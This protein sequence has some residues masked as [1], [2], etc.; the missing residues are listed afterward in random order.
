M[1]DLASN[2]IY[3]PPASTT[4][5]RREFNQYRSN[6]RLPRSGSRSTARRSRHIQQPSPFTSPILE[7]EDALPGIGVSGGGLGVAGGV[8]SSIIESGRQHGAHMSH[9]APYG[10]SGTVPRQQ[11]Q[12]RHVQHAGLRKAGIPTEENCSKEEDDVDPY[13]RPDEGGE[14]NMHGHPSSEITGV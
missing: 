2:S 7:D 12:P 14:S 6:H 11:Q 5:T 1:T 8:T 13:I 3:L 4:T 9:R 10:N